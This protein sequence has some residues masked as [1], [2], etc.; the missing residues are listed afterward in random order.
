DALVLASEAEAGNAEPVNLLLLFRRYLALEPDKAIA[1]RQTLPH[2]AAVEIGQGRGQKLDR[3][4]LVD[5]AAWLREQTRRLDV[6]GEDFAVAVDDIGSCPRTLRG[7]TARA[8]AVGAGRKHHQPSA[9]HG[10]HGNEGQN[11]ESDAGA[12]LRGAIDIAPVKQAANE[13]LAPRFARL[14]VRGDAAA[15]GCARCAGSEPVTEGA[16]LPASML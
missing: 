13:P 9:D 15:H 14:L 5:D 3:L 4:V 11:H 1:P 10:I 2:F 6:D 12:R 8:V 7:G 16:S